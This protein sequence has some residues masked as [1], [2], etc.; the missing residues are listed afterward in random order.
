LP[1]AALAARVRLSKASDVYRA[2]RATQREAQ[3][4]ALLAA[5]RTHWAPG[6]RVRYYRKKGGT[7]VWLPDEDGDTAD[8]QREDEN[9]AL[10][11]D[12]SPLL[13]RATREDARDY[14]VEHYLQVLVS[15]YAV[16]LR[17]AFAPQDFAQLFR[18]D[19]QLGLFDTPVEQI[20]PCWIRCQRGADGA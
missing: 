16:R 11:E 2:T 4:E 12:S 14:D 15:S 20:E 18:L 9:V 3:Y 1:A 8:H 10:P 6:E 19:A 17:K 13:N 7:Y 5:G